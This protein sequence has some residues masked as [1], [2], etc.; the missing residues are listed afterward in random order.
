MTFFKVNT[1]KLDLESEIMLRDM[2]NKLETEIL[3][4]D[5]K[6][7]HAYNQVINEFRFYN[8]DESVPELALISVQEALKWQ[9]IQF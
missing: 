6:N 7:I 2:K 8:I 4:G 1:P 5:L 3:A 9:V